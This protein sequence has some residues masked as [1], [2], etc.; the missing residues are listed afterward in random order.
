MDQET[1]KSKL[2]AFIKAGQQLT[3]SWDCGSDEAFAYL[4][5]DGEKIPWSNPI[6]DAMDLFLINRLE[7]PSAGDFSLQGKGTLELHEGKLWL[8]YA[9]ESEFYLEEEDYNYM[10]EAMKKHNPDQEIPPF[11]ENKGMQPDA[12]YSGRVELFV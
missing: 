6:A 5:I 4:H 8:V 2:E 7:L 11:E 9:S 12:E 10:V 1:L 3:V